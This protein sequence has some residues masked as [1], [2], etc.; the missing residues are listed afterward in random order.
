VLPAELYNDAFLGLC[1]GISAMVDPGHFDI[2]AL[3]VYLAGARMLHIVLDTS[4]FRTNPRRT[5]PAFRTLSALARGGKIKIHVPHVI[6]REFLSQQYEQIGAALQGL[7][8]QGKALGL[9]TA[10]P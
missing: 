1:A 5:S 4:T 9:T 7:K 6:K 8:K 2:L 10:D 3:R